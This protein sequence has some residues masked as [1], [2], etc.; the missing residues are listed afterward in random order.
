MAIA[1]SQLLRAVDLI[2]ANLR[3]PFSLKQVAEAG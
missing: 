2:C 3:R 1:I